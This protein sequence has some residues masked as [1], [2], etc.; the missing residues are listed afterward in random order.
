MLW[1]NKLQP[2]PQTETIFKRT[3]KLANNPLKRRNNT[4]SIHINTH[5]STE[6]RINELFVATYHVVIIRSNACTWTWKKAKEFHKNREEENRNRIKTNKNWNCILFLQTEKKIRLFTHPTSKWKREV[7]VWPYGTIHY[8]E[9]LCSLKCDVVFI[10]SLCIFCT[11][12][13]FSWNNSLL[14]CSLVLMLCHRINESPLYSHATYRYI[15]IRLYMY[16]NERS[17]CSVSERCYCRIMC[18]SRENWNESKW[19]EKTH[20][21]VRRKR[22]AQEKILINKSESSFVVVNLFFY[23]LSVFLQYIRHFSKQ[24]LM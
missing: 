4:K 22:T 6:T 10:L 24:L 14:R 11:V 8:N 20:V 12:F 5:S 13:L 19:N 18:F 23:I 2:L 17:V 7:I 1:I 16:A 15:T 3:Q 9:S 21:C